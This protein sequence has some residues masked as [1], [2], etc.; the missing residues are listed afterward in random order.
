LLVPH[1]IVMDLNNV[2]MQEI[3][4]CALLTLDKSYVA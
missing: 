4:S 3:F 2:T 1:N